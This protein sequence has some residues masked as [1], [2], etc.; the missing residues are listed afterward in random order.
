MDWLQVAQS[1]GVPVAILVTGG[2]G[3]WRCVVWLGREVVKPISDRHVKFIDDTT[4]A[5]DE[6]VKTQHIMQASMLRM[7]A[8]VLREATHDAKA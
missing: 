5:I 1:F 3:I 4:K 8:R 2:L 6:I 7:E